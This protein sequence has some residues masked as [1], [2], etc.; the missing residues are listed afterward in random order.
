MIL[1]YIQMTGRCL[2]QRAH[3]KK[4]AIA[5]PFFLIDLK[6]RYAG[7]RAHQAGLEAARS[8]FTAQATG[9]RNDERCGHL[10]CSGLLNACN[11]RWFKKTMDAQWIISLQPLNS[12]RSRLLPSDKCPKCQGPLAPHDHGRDALCVREV[13]QKTIP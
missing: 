4:Q 9:N 11:S 3:A 13:R 10:G 5:L 2:P 1:R 12:F 6:Y 8:L 7:G